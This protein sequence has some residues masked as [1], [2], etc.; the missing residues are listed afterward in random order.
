V[1]TLS[2]AVAFRSFAE[3]VADRARSRPDEVAV[4]GDEDAVTWQQLADRAGGLASL[5]GGTAAADAAA[6]VVVSTADAVALAVALVALAAVG[7]PSVVLDLTASPEQ[8]ARVAQHLGADTLLTDLPP[9]DR[10]L[11]PELRT[12]QLD[13][14]R[15]A[16]LAPCGVDPDGVALQLTTAGTT[17]V[18]KVIPVTHRTLAEDAYASLADGLVRPGDRLGRPR[19]SAGGTAGALVG[20]LLLG[21]PYVALDPRRIPPG[22]G[23]EAF[24]DHGVTYLHLTPSLLR[25]LTRGPAARGVRLAGLRLIGGGGE[26]MRW[27]DVAAIA[28]LLEPG[29]RVLHSYGSTEVGA[30]SRMLIDPHATLGVG[31][32]PVGRPVPGVT[33][34]IVPD[35]H[36]GNWRASDHRRAQVAAPQGEPGAIV[37]TRQGA[38]AVTPHVVAVPT[39]DLGRFDAEGLLHVIGRSDRM[40]KVG[41]VRV[42]P[43]AIEALLAE[44]PGV[45]DVA[46][47]AHDDERVG[48]RLVAHVSVLR[49][50]RERTAPSLLRERLIA[51]AI[52]GAAGT[53]V[54]V[55]QGR[56]PLMPS[57]KLDVERLRTS[58]T[59]SRGGSP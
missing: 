38:S 8:V 52:P 9:R 17:G 35:R 30:V 2:A 10:V 44:A 12:V 47:V 1:S 37:V 25:F 26:H 18:P 41:G 19:T 40:V 11:L 43:A 55:H 50:E 49:A 4:V 15:V 51:S 39:G 14:A 57:G 13:H 31:I 36:A 29:S 33:V 21:L 3:Q 32:V 53:T 20:A 59:A 22:R 58:V 45:D 56:L 48:T 34:D 54:V 6:P 23:L 27:S 24:V 5:L 42:E 16:D 28:P 7:R 46:I